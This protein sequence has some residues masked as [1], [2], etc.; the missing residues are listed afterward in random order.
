MVSCSG[1]TNPLFWYVGE[2]HLR[3]DRPCQNATKFLR[4][5]P[6]GHVVPKALNDTCAMSKSRSA[7]P[8]TTFTGDLLTA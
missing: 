3:L 6:K 2:A 1:D 5:G 7:Q 4:L 8:A